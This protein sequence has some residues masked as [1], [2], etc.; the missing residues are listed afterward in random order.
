MPTN[1][2]VALQNAEERKECDKTNSANDPLMRAESRANGAREL[3]NNNVNK[4][5]QQYTMHP[6]R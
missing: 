6:R 5:Q 4:K 1:S 2:C 3:Q